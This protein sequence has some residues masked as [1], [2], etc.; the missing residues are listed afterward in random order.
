MSKVRDLGVIIS[1]NLKWA[2]LISHIYRMASARALH[3]LR[4]FAS[5][6]FIVFVRLI[7]EYLV[8]LLSGHLTL[9]KTLM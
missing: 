6:A 1:C 4:G 3:I 8:I 5:H 2:G 7:V 9:K